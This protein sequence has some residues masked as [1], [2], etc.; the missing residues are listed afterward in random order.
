VRD[1]LKLAIAASALT[2]TKVGSSSASPT[3][4]KLAEFLKLKGEER[5]AEVVLE[6]SV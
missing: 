3:R 6:G 2:V 4:D 5:L 1:A